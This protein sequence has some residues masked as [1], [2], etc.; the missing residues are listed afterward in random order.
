MSLLGRFGSI[1]SQI[2]GVAIDPASNLL[3]HMNGIDESTTFTDSSTGGNS[4]HTV[5]AGGNV[6]I[7]TS[8]SVF[9]GA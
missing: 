6:Q 9:G 3:L 4:P 2:S 8:Q 1:A 7:D 5:S